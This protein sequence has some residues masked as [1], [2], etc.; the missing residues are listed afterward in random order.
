MT[1]ETIRRAKP[2]DLSEVYEILYE[3]QVETELHA[4]PSGAIPAV[5]D[6]ELETGDLYVAEEH[7][8]MVGFAALITRSSVAFVS[9][10]IVRPNYRS[11]GYGGALLRHILP[12]DGRACCMLS[13]N[14]PRA[15]SLSVRAGMRPQWPCYLLT[16]NTEDIGELPGEDVSIVEGRGNDPALEWWDAEVSRRH[17]PLDH[18]F[19]VRRTQAV[20]VW[21]RRKGQI[22]GYGYVQ[23]R[24]EEWLAHPDAITLGPIGTRTVDSS[25]A[26]VGAL[27]RW[28]ARPQPS[29][30][31]ILVP[32][33]HPAL[34]ALL[35]AA[36]RIAA[37]Y[38]F[39]SSADDPFP[40]QTYIPSGAAL[41]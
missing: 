15:L 9:E 39:V 8:E 1:G 18:T 29:S 21:F 5:F 24:S 27:A 30:M 13:Q 14:D 31:R 4:P 28:A 36:F 16:A 17:R 25:E 12:R 7:G 34:G 22:V 11:K 10:L 32:G 19:W 35:R 37:T 20:P 3:V 26:C 2:E 41:F 40:P 6:H 33:R 38:V 23:R